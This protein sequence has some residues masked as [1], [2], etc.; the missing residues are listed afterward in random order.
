[1]SG[2]RSLAVGE[3]VEFETDTKPDG[4]IQAINVTGPGGAEPK[5][6]PRE[7]RQGGFGGGGGGFGGGGYGQQSY[8]QQA[9]GGGG[10]YNQ[11]AYGQQAYGGGGGGGYGQQA[12]A[13][14]YGSY[15]QQAAAPQ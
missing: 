8:G 14:S 12:A 4:R 1:M 13:A 3:P 11:Q 5:G 7:P 2:F 9:Y 15:G 10:G 6:A